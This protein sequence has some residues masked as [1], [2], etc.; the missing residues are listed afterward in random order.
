MFLGANLRKNSTGP[1]CV[2]NVMLVEPVIR[3][4][5]DIRRPMDPS[6][7]FK[8]TTF[9]LNKVIVLKNKKHSHS[10]MGEFPVYISRQPS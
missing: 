4:C 2:I 5:I 3:R 9:I 10:K 1:S 8:S 7:H 6:A